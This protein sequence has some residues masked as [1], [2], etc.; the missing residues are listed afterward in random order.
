VNYDYSDVIGKSINHLTYNIHPEIE[1]QIKQVRK[2]ND[3]FSETVFKGKGLESM[4]KFRKKIGEK[5][6]P[7]IKNCKALYYYFYSIGTGA[8]GISTFNPVT[9]EK[10]ELLKRFRNVF[11]LSYQRYTDIAL[12]EA[13]AREAEIELALE[14]VRARTMA[15]QKSEEISETTHLLFEQL[16]NLGQT[17]AQLSIGIIKEEKGVFELSATVHGTS[18]LQTY[19]VPLDEPFVIKKAVKAWKQKKKTFTIELRGKELK[20]YN[21]WRNSVLKKKIVFPEKQ[22]I[23]NII[24]FSK[25]ML[26]FSSDK[27]ISKEA[28]QLL[29]RFAAVFDGTYTRFLDL[30]KAEAQ[31]RET[32][33]EVGLE[34]VRSRSLA[35][36][37]TSELQDIINTV[38]KEL[39]HLNIAIDGGSF[40]AINR[41]IKT[42]LRCWGSGG[43][44]DTT[45]EIHIPL[46]K[47]PF[48]SNIINSIKKGPGFFTEAFTQKEKK[49]FFTF[50][51]KHEPWK[52][53]NAKQKKENLSSPGGYTRSVCVSEHTSIFIINHLGE[54]FSADDNDILKRFG[55]V[56]EQSYTRFLDLQKA[57]AQTRESQIELGLERVRARAMAMQHSDEL[58]QLVDTVFK[59]LASLDFALNWCIINIIDEPSLTNMVWAANPDTNKPPESYLMKFEDYPFH[60]SMLKGYRERKPK[61]VYVIEGKEKKEYDD[62]LF[63]E[64]EWR[65]V[66]KKAQ[67]ASRAMKRYVASFT[68]S[69]FGGLQTV[70]EEPLSD[71]SL[72]I[73]HRFGKVFDGTYTRFN[74]LLRSEAQ[75]RE[76]EIELALERVRART[77]AMQHSDELSAASLL[78]DQQVRAL[79]IKT[80]GCAFNIYGKDESTEWFSSEAGTIPSYKTPREKIFKKYYQLGLSGTAL[81]IEEF[82]DKACAKHYDYLETIPIMGDDIRH[83]KKIGAVPARQIDHIAY[84]KYGYLLFVT[85]EAV[86]EA[87]DIFKRFAKVFE[88]TY[89]R[90]LDLQKAEAQAREAEIDLALERVRSQAMAMQKSTDLLDI[91][92]TMRTEFTRLG[93]EAHYFWH[94]M[95]LPDKYEKAM[96]SG[97]GTKIGF[98]MELPRHIHGDIPLLAKWEKSK[99]PTEVYAMNVEEALDYV[100]KMVSLGD[101]KNIDPQAPSDDDIRHIGGLTFIMARTTHGEIGF[102]LPGVV[103]NPPKEDL[104]ILIRFAGAFDIAHRRFLDLQ[105]SEAQSREVEIELA[106]EKVRSRSMGMQKS[107]ELKEVIKVVYEQFV[108]LNINVE[109][110]GFIM[111]YKERDDMHIWLADQHLV[112]SEVF[113]P[114]FDSAHWNS[115]REAKE[116][117]TDFFPTLLDFE[118]KNK[119]YQD[120]FKLI[121]GVPEETLEYYF[122]CPGLGGSTVLL[123]NVSLY[124]ENFQGIPYTDEENKILMRFGKVFQQTYTRFLDLQKAEAQASEAKIEAALERTRTQSMIMQHSNE[125]DDALRVFHEQVLLLGI[126]SEFSYLWLPDEEKNNHLFWATWAEQQ[127]GSTIF[128]SKALTYDLDRT[129]PYTAVCIAAWKSDIPVH[130]YTLLPAE[131]K[132]YFAAWKELLEDVENLKPALFPEGLYYVEAFM[133]Y[134]CFGVMIKNELSEEKKKILGRFSIEFERT[135]TRFL[136]LKK[137]EAQARE[138]QIEAA[139]EKVRSRSMAMYRS[140]E[141]KEAGE[142]LWN[143]LTKLGIESLSSGYVLMDQKE[144]IGWIYAPNPATGKIAEPIGVLHKETKEMLA[145]LSSWKKQAP[146]CI[147]EMNEEETIVHQTFIAERSLH[148]DGTILRWITSEQLIALSPKRLFL[149][150]FNFKEG[151][152]LIVGGNK[153]KGE[154]IELLLR[155]TKVFQQT[156]TRFL[157]LQKAEAQAREAKIEMALEKIRSRT[158]AMQRSDELPEAANLLFLEVQALGIPAWS[159][160]YNILSEDKKSST[161]IMSSEGLIQSAF[162]LPFNNSGEPSFAEWL[163]AIEKQEPFFVQELSGKKIED[164]YN[165][166]KTLP[167]VG[168]AIRELEDAGLSLP[169]YQINHLCRFTNGFLLF[170]TYE[171][172]PHAHDIFQRFT[173]VFEQTYTRF[174]DLQKAEAQAR[175]AQ[176]EMALEKVRSRTMAMQRSDELSGTAAMLFQEFKK[177]EQQE[178]IQT[179]IG[180]YNEEKNEIEFRATDWTGSG[181]QVNKPSYGSMD[182]PTLLKPAVTAWRA[183]ARSVVIELTGKALEKWTNYRNKMTGTSIATKF[184]GGRRIVS[185]AFFSKGHLSMSSPLPIPPEAV[186]TLERFAAVFDGTYTRFLDLQKAEAQARES[187]I[188]AGLERVR[189]RTLAMQNSDELAETSVV[190]FKQLIELG[191]EP[192]RL[193]IGIIK[194]DSGDIEFWATDE[195][196]TKISSKFTGNK[197]YNGSVKKMY[198]NWVAQE[199]SLTIDMQG[200]ELEDYFH[201]LG[202]VMHVPFKQ[203]LSQKR[204]VQTMSFF[205]KGFI[206]IASPDEQPE[207]TTKLLERFAAVFNLT[208]TRF[209]DLQIAEAQTREAKIETALERVRARALAMQEPEELKEV[210]EVLRHEMG[211]LGVE[212]LETCSIYINDENAEKAECW[213][214]LKDLRSE[215]KKLVN[216]HFALNLNDTWVGRE[217][218]SFYNSEEKQISILMAGASRVEWIR[219]CEANSAPFRGY[220]GDEIPDRTYHLYKFSH[221]AIGAASAGDISTESWSLLKRAASVFS[222]AYSRFKDLTQARVDLQRLKEEKQKAEDALTNL[223]AAQKQLVQSEKMASLGELTAGIA[224]EIQNP[225]NFVNNF[226]EVSKELLDE[227]KEEMDKGNLDDVRDIMKD[228]I[229][230]LEKINHH[231]KRADGIVKGMLQHS[232]SSSGSKE[233]TDINALADEYLRLAYHGLR[234]KDKSFNA[235]MKT[236]FDKSLEKVNV[237]PQDIGRVILN[238]ITNAFYVVNEKKN[239]PQPP[240]VGGG[241]P[242]EP[243]VSVSSKK[244]GDKILISVNDNGNG[245]PQKVLDKIFQPFFTTKPTGQGTGLGLSL[246]FDIVTKGHGGELKVE[247]KEGEGT[248]FIILLPV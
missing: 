239:T 112:P 44:A 15:M 119:F 5:D 34:R 79:G 125:L 184:D 197:K 28:F 248:E 88:Q 53:L 210:A 179:T 23:I 162:H 32:Q 164:H 178:L 145:V 55:K 130:S 84:F 206:G 140:D 133:K 7:R 205:S 94:M 118:E 231:G 155:F 97:D 111:D 208:Y 16:K 188:E 236:D 17:A 50:L 108:H 160:G 222:L 109:H 117:G 246:A 170:I 137:A 230:N 216:D 186:K 121:P 146:L 73:L 227:M 201:Y 207:E 148:P 18:L 99:K 122:N 107:E 211:L 8:I 1:K 4:K 59:E 89:T 144:K 52:K 71:E 80:R 116:K 87:H 182:E 209:N 12:A 135:Y 96:T 168:Q 66:P 237:I 169:T 152:L 241:V 95:W 13:Q 74:D 77:M 192:N 143:E 177:L 126:N 138:A 223:Q 166:M 202:D 62:Y 240:P 220:Y 134:G 64:T 142:L 132:N 247:T 200:K 27:E 30:Q 56:F 124:I 36:H 81:H 104:D 75:A 150:N 131:V 154:Q 67:V 78:L 141:L 114:Y 3:A 172:V 190:V 174:L 161:C 105:K 102:S 120:L 25:G 38:H 191:I 157:D 63:N 171:P 159:A 72:D 245:I 69:N 127:D 129:E 204:R 232:R 45:E 139:L 100:H 57:E 244:I 215:E 183:H 68:F 218:L 54:I 176:I 163:E 26:S 212:E 60:H 195:D 2:A 103:E 167:Q 10:L 93:H 173:K 224:H 234:A 214:A 203:G 165:Y 123:D 46:Y 40:I 115:F 147:I 175:E 187:Q 9:K 41:D 233:P 235:T 31:V 19:N 199:K 110:T 76:A 24:F 242:Y 158:M 198:D 213:Y 238:L 90:F 86:A 29:E 217:M 189:S 82:D 39:L 194:D 228:V 85:L 149:H 229:Q 61:H 196:G 49:D 48:C 20:A 43:T 221:G 151:Y 113:I 92:V 153:L 51:F 243:T 14:R 70:T 226:S 65:R 21:K 11:A 185:I 101:F 128:K 42:N 106:L 91:V 35:M 33:I 225:L 47:K 98:V 22:W 37:N 219:F 180:I 136:D 181:E 6:D 58:S 193:Y 83:L 156:Y